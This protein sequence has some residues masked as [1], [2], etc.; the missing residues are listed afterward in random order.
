L[1]Y[2]WLLYLHLASVAGFL[3]AHGSAAATSFALRR[4]TGADGVRALLD[5]SLLFAPVTYV[6]LLLIIASGVALGFA[7]H[8]WATGWIWVSLAVLVLVSGAMIGLGMPYN[9]LRQALG[10][11]RGRRGAEAA[12]PPRPPEEVRRA[13]AATRPV[14]TALVGVIALAVLL[15]LMTSKPF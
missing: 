13:M 12:A 1:V 2:T 8:W 7:G 15:W 14:I 5:Q 4:Q 9:A 10:G 11:P 3:L 6:F